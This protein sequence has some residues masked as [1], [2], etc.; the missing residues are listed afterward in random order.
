M[1]RFSAESGES[2]GTPL[3]VINDGICPSILVSRVEKSDTWPNNQAK[4]ATTIGNTAFKM[5]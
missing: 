5:S 3:E 4:H 1:W 2:V